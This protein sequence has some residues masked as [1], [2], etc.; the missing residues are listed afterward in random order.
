MNTKTGPMNHNLFTHKTLAATIRHLL[1]A[2]AVG[3]IMLGSLQT[4]QAN[5]TGG[6]VMAGSAEIVQQ[7]ARMDINQASQRAVINWQSFSIDHGEHVNFNQPGRDAATL[8][9]VIGNDPSAILGRLT[10]NGNVYLVNQNGIL[11]GKD[12]QINVGSLIATTANINTQDFMEGRMIFNE[13]G[14]ADARIVNYGNI[15]VQ[16]GGLVALVAPGIENHGAIHAKLGKI[17]L[18]S[19]EAFTLDLYGDQ[20][21]N[22]TVTPEQ[23]TQIIGADGKPLSNSVSNTGEIIADGGI[24]TLMAGTGKAIVD[25]LINLQGYVQAQTVENRNGVITLMGDEGTTVNVAGVLDASGQTE[26]AQGGQVEIRAGEVNLQ[27]GSL[28]DVSGRSDGGIALV[29]GDFQGSGDGVRAQNTTVARHAVI[30]ADSKI[31]GDG[32]KVIVWADDNTV[33]EGVIDARGGSE[34]GNGGF[35]EVSGK[36]TLH[37]DGD[38]DASAKNGKAGQLLLD[39]GDLTVA[40]LTSQENQ[41]AMQPTVNGDDASWQV[42]AT[43]RVVNVQKINYLLQGGT[44]VSLQA[45]NDLNVNAQIDGRATDGTAGGGVDLE[46]GRDANI[47]EN[48]LT[49]NGK[50]SINASR[51]ITMAENKALVVYT[52]QDNAESA[53]NITLEAGRNINAQHLVTTGKIELTADAGKITL[54]QSLAG[55]KDNDTNRGIGAL[56]VNATDDVFLN[57]IQSNAEVKVL[58]NA[59]EI[60]VA[61]PIVASGEVDLSGKTIN[62]AEEAVIDTRGIAGD[63]TGNELKLTTVN[64][65]IINANMVTDDAKIT[66]QSNLGSIKAS[67]NSIIESGNGSSGSIHLNA[68]QNL[69]LGRLSSSG[70]IILKTDGYLEALGSIYGADLEV[71]PL[72]PIHGGDVSLKGNIKL[73]N[74]FLDGDSLAPFRL[75]N[76]ASEEGGIEIKGIVAMIDQV[77]AEEGQDGIKIT[78]AADRNVEV[79]AKNNIEMNYVFTQ[80]DLNVSSQDGDITLN[81]PLGAITTQYEWPNNINIISDDNFLIKNITVMGSKKIDVGDLLLSESLNIYQTSEDSRLNL[82][83]RIDVI[84]GDIFIGR[85]NLDDLFNLIDVTEYPDSSDITLHGS[86]YAHGDSK[87]II[88]NNNLS[89]FSFKESIELSDVVLNSGLIPNN[90]LA[91]RTGIDEN[92]NFIPFYDDDFAYGYTHYDKLKLNTIFKDASIISNRSGKVELRGSLLTPGLL[93]VIAKLDINNNDK[94]MPNGF[95]IST[96]DGRVPDSFEANNIIIS[97]SIEESHSGSSNGSGWLYPNEDPTFYPYGTGPTWLMVYAENGNQDVFNGEYTTIINFDG[98]G[99]VRDI[100]KLKD[101]E[102]IYNLYSSNDLWGSSVGGYENF[103]ERYGE[104]DKS[105]NIYKMTFGNKDEVLSTIT[106]IP[107]YGQGPNSIQQST[108][109]NSIKRNTLT[110]INTIIS[111]PGAGQTN[112]T[113]GFDPGAIGSRVADTVTNVGGINNQ[114]L[115]TDAVNSATNQTLGYANQGI[116]QSQDSSDEEDDSDDRPEI[117]FFAT[118]SEAQN[119]DLGRG[120]PEDGAT[121]L[122]SIMNTR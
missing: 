1:A 51:D 46:A 16:Q 66:V 14:H 106:S 5:P 68:K 95:S 121:M 7:G 82:F 113:G 119:A 103:Y 49:H 73:Q 53:Q 88:I 84:D 74:V 9:R 6:Q 85:K 96:Q 38:V 22:L 63:K 61:A 57:G 56:H 118:S 105:N 94:G 109:A 69:L 120:S 102:Y 18:A 31:A 108:I 101:D 8:N 100:L 23:L 90:H 24:V 10:A 32:G 64:D 3:A 40:V 112:P 91:Y 21:I 92:G 37:F 17:S 43:D 33:F 34:A 75:D 99:G 79:K 30:D 114:N 44:N 67:E 115:G 48:I 116:S 122:R 58:S 25:S 117:I 65:V 97:N 55:I 76:T 98:E 59:G 19:G 42:G 89:S 110:Q 39:P 20:L 4:A 36:N 26:S 111:N 47:N 28:I 15:T 50:I 80:G 81:Q 27:D 93:Q 54:N 87:K 78:S 83:G 104:I 60:K 77:Q 62:I 35:V 29:G 71:L 107:A 12:A 52:E 13:A 70:A 2:Q 11:V 86:I 45:S 72:T 41:T